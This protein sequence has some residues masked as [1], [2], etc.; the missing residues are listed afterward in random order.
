[1]DKNYIFY[2]EVILYSS[3]IYFGEL[4][5]FYTIFSIFGKALPTFVYF[6]PIIVTAVFITPVY[7]FFNISKPLYCWVY[8]LSG[9]IHSYLLNQFLF[10]LLYQ[11]IN[12]LIPM[13]LWYGIF[14]ELIAP[15]F[16][17]LFGLINARIIQTTKVSLK[18]KG[19]KQK[20]TIAH[21]SDL[22]L[23]AVYQKNYVQRV[24]NKLKQLN[25]DIIVITGDLADGSL[26]FEEDWI[27]PFNQLTQPILFISGNHEEIAN[28]KLVLN[29]VMDT[30]IKYIGGEIFECQGINFIGIDYEDDSR[31]KLKE[32][33]LKET[34]KPNIL[35]YHVPELYPRE[36][37]Q[38]NLFL[39][40]A[41]HTHG[42][43]SIPIHFPTWLL[44]AC[45]YGLYPDNTN[46]R[47]VYVTSGVG[48]ALTPLRT[49]SKSEIALIT[50]EP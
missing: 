44:N 47:F 28:K 16:Y 25:P 20:K 23:G 24:V 42:G 4:L 26:D 1:M 36:L 45:F 43:Q 32:F 5:S 48:T 12:F 49:F 39:H 33:E 7:L 31:K 6:L 41:G 9:A 30:K 21:L 34:E 15:F 19:L 37:K 22:H 18:Y 27:K 2:I 38:Y 13:S 50:I 29:C 46:E 8:F 3:L 35:L 17:N 10:S 14:F 40:L 11:I